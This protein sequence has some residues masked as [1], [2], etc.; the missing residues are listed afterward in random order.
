MSTD[1]ASYNVPTKAE[2]LKIDRTGGHSIPLDRF[3]IAHFDSTDLSKAQRRTLCRMA[4]WEG[5]DVKACF[6]QYGFLMINAIGT[7]YSINDYALFTIGKRGAIR[8]DLYYGWS[9]RKQKI[10]FGFP[11]VRGHVSERADSRACDRRVAAIRR[12]R[13]EEVTR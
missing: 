4:E 13:A 11:Q 9:R 8:G 10:T 1:A 6:H 12:Q 2:A 5:V 3:L 7:Q